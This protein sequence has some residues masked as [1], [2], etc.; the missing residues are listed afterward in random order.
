MVRF[1]TKSV[2]LYLKKFEIHIF[3][4][5]GATSWYQ[6]RS[7]S[8]PYSMRH[9]IGLKPFSRLF[10]GR[11]GL[12]ESVGFGLF[13]LLLMVDILIDRSIIFLSIS[14]L[15]IRRLFSFHRKMVSTR[16]NPNG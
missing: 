1:R 14:V 6:S 16:A 10:L 15:N 3:I 5:F 4:K 13:K 7:L 12:R 8:E 9:R 11:V 2:S